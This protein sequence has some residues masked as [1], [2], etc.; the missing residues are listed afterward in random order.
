VTTLIIGALLLVLWILALNSFRLRNW[1]AMT[2]AGAGSLAILVA[3]SIPWPAAAPI[4]IVLWTAVMWTFLFRSEWV[5]VISQSE[6]QYLE[7]Y[8]GILQGLARVF[9]RG[10][11]TDEAT[12][13]AQFETAVQSLDRLDA[14]DE[15]RQIQIDTVAELRL[16]LTKMKL[17]SIPSP[18]ER[19]AAEARWMEIERRF[20]ATVNERVGFWRGWPRLSRRS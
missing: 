17:R 16:R 15:W 12:Y 1:R 18:D 10:R 11:E 13:V 9:R 8:D 6:Y 19:L 5:G 20:R 4:Q 7:Q 3:G 14:P 2:L